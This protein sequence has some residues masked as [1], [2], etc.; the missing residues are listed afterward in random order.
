M[1]L[2]SRKPI[3]L[4]MNLGGFETRMDELLTKAFCLG[5]EVFSLTGEGIVPLAAQRTIVP[6]NVMSLSSGELHVWSSLV[7]EQL[8][9]REMNVANVVILAAGRK[10]CGV[11]PLG[12]II[13]EGLR[14][15]A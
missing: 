4:L 7:N 12:T 13:F 6:V 10:Y 8:Q 2:S 14:I 9:E 11:L 5:E 3:C 1:R 15:G